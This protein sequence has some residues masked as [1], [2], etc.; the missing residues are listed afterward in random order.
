M[1]LKS[2]TSRNYCQGCWQ[3]IRLKL[4]KYNLSHWNKN[5]KNTEKRNTIVEF[6]E[7]TKHN[8]NSAQ[9]WSVWSVSLRPKP[10]GQDH[11]NLS[12][13]TSD[14]FAVNWIHCDKGHSIQFWEIHCPMQLSSLSRPELQINYTSDLVGQHP[15]ATS[16]TTFA[17]LLWKI[18]HFTY[19]RWRSEHF[20]HHVYLTV[21]S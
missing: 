5:L 9:L 2:S 1:L 18:L 17:S 3:E 20:K 15:F 19:W 7:Q 16:L 12:S 6:L 8:S 4:N 14:V 13:R 21:G 11:L 10:T